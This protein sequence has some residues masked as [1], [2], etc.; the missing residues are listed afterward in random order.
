MCLTWKAAECGSIIIPVKKSV[1]S[2]RENTKVSVTDLLHGAY[3]NYYIGG[4]SFNLK[5][6]VFT[7]DR[8]FWLAKLSVRL[9]RKGVYPFLKLNDNNVSLQTLAVAQ[10]KGYR[11]GYV[12][13]YERNFSCIGLESLTPDE[14]KKLQ[15]TEEL[16]KNEIKYFKYNN[17]EYGCITF[18]SGCT[19]TFLKNEIDKVADKIKKVR[20]LGN[21][22]TLDSGIKPYKLKKDK[23]IFISQNLN[24]TDFF[25]CEVITSDPLNYAFLFKFDIDMLAYENHLHENFSFTPDGGFDSFFQF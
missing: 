1:I 22:K 9:K 10:S 5:S 4:I 25:P 3:F 15:S 17:L 11:K 2:L 21:R 16:R 7:N 19:I 12:Q 8:L 23:S 14:L 13:D 24:L 18:K 20:V 6:N